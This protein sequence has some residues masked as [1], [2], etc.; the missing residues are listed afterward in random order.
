[1]S[2]TPES[3]DF[4]SNLGTLWSVIL[5]ALLATA[6]GLA[7]GQ[8]EYVLESQRRQRDSALFFAEVLST[9]KTL[10]D[11]ASNARKIGDPYGPVTMRMLH[12]ARR[13]IDIYERNRETLFAI[14]DGALR[15]RIHTVV[16]RITMPLEGI[17]DTTNALETVT[18]QLAVPNL[19]EREHDE[20]E[21]RRI[22]L[23]E[24]RNGGFD[25]MMDTLEM[26][27]PII[28][29]LGKLA[30]QD[31]TGYE[32]SMFTGTRIGPQPTGAGRT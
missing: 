26:A 23:A 15:G 28:A 18:T 14:R 17:F 16:L 11:L 31:F 25:F 4:L 6:G 8:L 22:Q 9:L 20:L 21:R 1:M 5:G 19:P 29:D 27:K 30:G 3:F 7:G 10:L 12:S 2:L 13:E 32:Q 24:N